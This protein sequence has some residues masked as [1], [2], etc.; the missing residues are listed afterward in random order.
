MKNFLVFCVLIIGQLAAQRLEIRTTN[1]TSSES[2][3]LTGAKFKADENRKTIEN[4]YYNKLNELVKIELYEQPTDS[5]TLN[6]S[7]TE[8]FSYLNGKL[9]AKTRRLGW[10]EVPFRYTEKYTYNTK[11]LRSRVETKNFK[12]NVLYWHAISSYYY[13]E[14]DSV[15]TQVDSSSYGEKPTQWWVL[16]TNFKYDDKNRLVQTSGYENQKAVNEE[17]F[18]TISY[19]DQNERSIVISNYLYQ[20][21]VSRA[22]TV[23]TTKMVNGTKKEINYFSTKK[24]E[25]YNEKGWLIEETDTAAYQHARTQYFYLPNGKLSSS[26]AVLDQS[27]SSYAHRT[28]YSIVADYTYDDANRL[29]SVLNKGWF[30]TTHGYPNIKFFFENKAI[31]GH[32]TIENIKNEP[33]ILVYPN[34]ATNQIHITNTLDYDCFYAIKMYNQA[35]G[36][37]HEQ[38]F[39]NEIEESKGVCSKTIKLPNLQNGLYFLMIET[40]SKA[41]IKKNIMIQN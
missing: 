22:D 6:L 27:M 18:R 35:G 3:E 15:Q 33:S 13:N 26:I 30:K 7:T 37:V 21:K 25:Y 24:T 19:Q 17:V 12:D 34:P 31:S 36:L 1:F 8:D 2:Q 11:G 38:T 4:K 9:S 23:T 40:G 5:S 29:I 32:Q 20:G 41:Q 28:S 10:T 39:I 14:V 16:T